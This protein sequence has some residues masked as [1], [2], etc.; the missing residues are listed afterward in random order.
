MLL[1]RIAHQTRTRG[2]SEVPIGTFPEFSKVSFDFPIS[3][4][5]GLGTCI[6]KQSGLVLFTKR[7]VS[8][9]Q[10]NTGYSVVRTCLQISDSGLGLLPEFALSGAQ[11]GDFLSIIRVGMTCSV[12]P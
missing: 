3:E 11:K 1:C 7:S 12:R 9:D 5:P 2:H 8:L 4:F 6:R 10:A